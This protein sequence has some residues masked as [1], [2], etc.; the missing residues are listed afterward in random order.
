M[1]QEERLDYLL[2]V[3]SKEAG[4]EKVPLFLDLERKR[5]FLR[6]LMNVRPPLEM[7][8]EI[9]KVQDE[10]LKARNKERGIVDYKK[11]PTIKEEGSKQKWGS[12][13]SLWQGD[14]TRLNCAALVN[15]ANSQMLG[16]FIPLHYCVDNA[17]HTYAGAELRRACY[18]KMQKLKEQFGPSYSQ[19]VAIPLMTPAYNLPAQK[20]IHIVGP[21]V[22]GRLISKHEEDL[23]NC[24]LNS[25]NLC[26]EEGLQSVAFC[27]LSTGEFSFPN[28]RAAEIAVKAVND[29]LD[30]HADKIERIIFNVYKDL[31]REHYKNELF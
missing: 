25:L 9:L 4:I 11:I 13:I 19:K 31:D 1:T 30:D 3:L 27:C 6:S 24:Y 5:S 7:K 10:Y 21:I 16:C 12:K 17:I 18:L 14:I 23:R 29:W 15:A 20:I 28:Q 26:V 2:E 22:E 8:S